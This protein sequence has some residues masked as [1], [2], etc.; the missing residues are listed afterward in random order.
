MRKINEDK[1]FRKYPKLFPGGRK[2]DPKQSLM[3]YGIC[4]NEGWY[5][6][7]DKLCSDIQK[8]V[9][10][11][12]ELEQI[13]VIQ[14]KEKFGGLRFYIRHGAQSISNLIHKA[15]AESFET[16]EDC[17]KKGNIIKTE[18]GWLRTLCKSC[19]K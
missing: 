6:L 3:N 19:K 12:P 1:L 10:K 8:I 5:D 13:Q 7:V 15:E 14:V 4:V 9:D 18:R 11:T 2:V 16:C 17:G